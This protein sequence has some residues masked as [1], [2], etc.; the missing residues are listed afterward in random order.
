[1]SLENDDFREEFEREVLRPL[2]AAG[3]DPAKLL[4]EWDSLFLSAESEQPDMIVEQHSAPSVVPQEQTA[5]S[6]RDIVQ[7]IQKTIADVFSICLGDCEG[8]SRKFVAGVLGETSTPQDNNREVPLPQHMAS[9]VPWICRLEI[10]RLDVP[11]DEG[12]SNYRVR[13]PLNADATVTNG[14]LLVT[15]VGPEDTRQERLLSAEKPVAHFQNFAD[16]WERVRME[17]RVMA[18]QS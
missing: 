1:M 10:W 17:I 16:E 8:T 2:R 18:G 14:K 15:L 11:A 3:V 7:Y 6:P 4:A 9:L 13:I 12:R 5:S